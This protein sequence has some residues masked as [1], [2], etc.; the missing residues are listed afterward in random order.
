MT[1]TH[2]VVDPA[3]EDEV[4][5][6]ALTS[7]EETDAGHRARRTPRSARWRERRTGRPGPAAAPVRRRGRRC[8]RGARAARG[9]QLR[10]HHLQRPLG[11]RQRPGRP[12]LLR[13]RAGAAVRPADPGRRR[14]RHHLQG[15][16]RRR[17]GHRAVELPDADRRLGVRAGAG[18]RQHRRA[19]AGRADPADR[20]ADRRAGARGRAAR[21]RAHRAARQGVGRRASASWPTRWSARSA[22]PA[23][24]RSAPGSWPGRPSR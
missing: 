8:D 23:R 22:S 10:P 2:V 19:Q 12:R 20:D 9:A 7:A 11:G 24:P 14:R 6:V 13:R 1:Q 15:A 21:A 3:T 18:C 5:T 16:A 17:R 4:A